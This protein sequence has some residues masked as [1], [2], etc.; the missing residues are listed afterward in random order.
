MIL[1][2]DFK[3]DRFKRTKNRV[4]VGAG[5]RG[6]LFRR[7]VKNAFLQMRLITLKKTRIF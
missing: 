6:Y 1:L 4:V 2:P 5:V 7:Q 3:E